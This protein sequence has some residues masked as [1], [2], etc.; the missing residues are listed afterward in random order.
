MVFEM[1]PTHYQTDPHFLDLNYPTLSRPPPPTFSAEKLERA[2]RWARFGNQSGSG[3]GPGAP[4]AA[5]AADGHD[6]WCNRLSG[7][8]CDL[9]D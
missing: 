4:P 6:E 9:V 1:I 3:L 5:A 7:P 8:G 2:P